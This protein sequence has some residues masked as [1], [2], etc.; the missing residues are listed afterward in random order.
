MA[1][2]R[3]VGQ[4]CHVACREAKRRLGC[5]VYMTALGF[6][7]IALSSTAAGVECAENAALHYWVAFALCPPE[8]EIISAATTDDPRFGFGIPVSQELAN[9]FSGRGARALE[10]LHR[11]AKVVSCEWGTN[12]RK[13]GPHDDV[14]HGEK[15]HGL[16]RLALLRARWRFEHDNWES[17]VRDVIA[18]MRLA[19]HVGRD[20][21]SF[22]IR[23]GCMLDA[24]AIGTAAAYLPDMP[25][26]AR[27]MLAAELDALPNPTS[28]REAVLYHVNAIDWAIERFERT[29]DPGRLREL[30][31][32]ISSKDEAER[33]MRLAGNAEGLA[34]ISHHAD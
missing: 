25:R 5:R 14:V 24:M 10:H 13:N 6:W 21:V 30:V 17:G 11:G 1:G 26:Q 16:G 3:R 29:E 4:R 7:A 8:T 23:Y 2:M 31:A 18:T 22:N 33:I 19:R 9:Q 27:Q 15:A 34:R 20:K 12:L 32:T 28:M